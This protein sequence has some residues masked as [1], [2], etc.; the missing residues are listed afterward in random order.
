MDKPE[1]QMQSFRD[2]LDIC[3]LKDLGFNGFPFT[4]CNR[5]PRDKNVWIRIDKGV[6][7]IEWILRFPTTRIHHLDFFHLNHKPVLLCMDSEL[8]RFY[9]KSQPFRFEAMWLKDNA[10]EGVI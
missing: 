7:T 8:N 2:A 5:R 3:R 4:W 1:A 10:C 6:A 9:R